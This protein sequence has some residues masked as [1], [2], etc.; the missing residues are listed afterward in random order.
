M[1][2]KGKFNGTKESLGA[3]KL[4]QQVVTTVPILALP[5]FSRPF[6]I[7][8]DASSKEVGVV[9]TQDKKPN[10]L[11]KK[12]LLNLLSKYI[13]EKELMALVL[14]IQHWRPYLM[15]QIFIVFIH[16]KSLRCLLEQR[17]TTQNQQNWF[18]KLLT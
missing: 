2:K 4:L 1:L 16:Q 12:G 15:G 18:A 5:D 9:L 8:C 11:F 14:T 3:F 10:C 13:H 17:I 7:Q 6:S